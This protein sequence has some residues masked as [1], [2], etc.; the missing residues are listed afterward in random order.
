MS[1]LDRQTR[2][3][4]RVAT[5]KTF[6]HPLQIDTFR[7]RIPPESRILDYGCGYGRMSTYL[8]ENGYNDIT[9]IDI[10]PAM[11]ERG[12][13]L[14]PGLN[15]QPLEKGAL[16]FAGNQFDACIL[17]A[18]LT[19]IPTDGGQQDLIDELCRVLRPKGIVYLSD[20]PLQQDPRNR[21]RYRNFEDE[22]GKRGVFR[23]SDGGV[24]RHHEMAW[25]YDLLADFEI[26]KEQTLAVRTMNGNLSSIFQIMAEKR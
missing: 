4:D 18:V 17:L 9:G 13:S 19:C 14:Y 7:E 8:M 21:E 15:L 3:W 26:L 5:Q 10:S 6:T 1:E 12:L 16:P 23:L 2:Y 11:I 25:I 20:Y 24:V 22:F